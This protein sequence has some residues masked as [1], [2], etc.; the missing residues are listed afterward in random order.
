MILLWH[1][2]IHQP[3]SV[4]D[5]AEHADWSDLV[6]GS[7]L[8]RWEMHLPSVHHRDREWGMGCLSQEESGWCSEEEQRGC[9]ADKDYHLPSCDPL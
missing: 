6:S 2:S 8:R 7:T 5:R 3:L 1:M 4:T 9:W